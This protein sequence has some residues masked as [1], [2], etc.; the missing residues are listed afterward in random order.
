MVATETYGSSQQVTAFLMQCLINMFK[1][2]IDFLGGKMSEQHYLGIIRED[3]IHLLLLQPHDK[4]DSYCIKLVYEQEEIF[5][6]NYEYLLFPDCQKLNAVLS[7]QDNKFINCD[8]NFENLCFKIYKI[9]YPLLSIKVYGKDNGELCEIKPYSPSYS[10]DELYPVTS[11]ERECVFTSERYRLKDVDTLLFVLRQVHNYPKG[12]MGYV[13]NARVVFGYRALEIGNRLIIYEAIDML[14]QGIDDAYYFPENGH[15]RNGKICSMLSL[16]TV[17]CHLLLY[18]KEINILKTTCENFFKI[19][20]E[21][22]KYRIQY[23]YNHVRILAIYLLLIYSMKCD[24]KIILSLIEKIKYA[25][26]KGACASKPLE[27]KRA[28]TIKEIGETAHVV[29]LAM[30]LGYNLENKNSSVNDDF[31]NLSQKAFRCKNQELRK[32]I[33]SLCA[34]R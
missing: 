25:F 19:I 24:S 26:Y 7:E 8:E 4:F 10:L 23:T 21:V 9:S 34:S 16:V 12:D 31:D 33:Q 3:G 11:H 20:D 28:N 6:E 1:Y 5:Y 13:N 32:I 30:R 29:F 14:D 27:N 2:F 22:K 17:K 15:V 18:L